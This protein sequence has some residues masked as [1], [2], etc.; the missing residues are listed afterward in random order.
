MSA[1]KNTEPVNTFRVRIIT[2]RETVYDGD[3][4]R[5]ELSTLDGIMEMLP[6]HEPIMAPL[7][8]APLVLAPPGQSESVRFSLLGGFLNWDGVEADILA[9][10][11]EVGPDINIDRARQAWQR[12]RE[13]LAE[14]SRNASDGG[15]DV[16]RAKLAMLRSLARLAAAGQQVSR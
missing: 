8:I 12:A 13:R 7:A 1:Q 9:D 3:A 15:V 4:A 5:M 2:P 16:D 11:A 6:R 14:A 10:E